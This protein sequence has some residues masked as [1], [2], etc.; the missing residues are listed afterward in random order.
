MRILLHNKADEQ[1]HGY[2]LQYHSVRVDISQ[3]PSP[4]M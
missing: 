2:R 1:T 4:T 3:E